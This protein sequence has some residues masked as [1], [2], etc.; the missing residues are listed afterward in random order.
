MV[1]PLRGASATPIK[2]ALRAADPFPGLDGFAGQLPDGRLVRDV[3]GREPL[4]VEGEDWAWDPRE[5]TDPDPFPAGSVG[6]PGAGPQSCLTIPRGR[7]AEPTVARDRLGAAIDAAL[8]A[9]PQGTPVGFSGGVDSGL[10]ATASAGPL[11]VVGLSDAPDVAA[12]R[13][14]ADAMGRRLR[15][16]D[17]S[18]SD[19]EEAVPRVARSIGLRDPM[20]VAIAMGFYQLGTAVAADGHDR[21]ALGQGADELF[22]GY[23]KVASAPT[24]DRL[25]AETVRDARDEMLRT[26]PHQAARD[27]A[28]LR[29]AGVEPVM[30]LLTDGVVTAALTLPSSMLVRDGVRKW[31]LRE[32]ARDRLPASVVGREKTAMQYGSRISREIDRLARQAGFKRRE[33]DHVRRYIQARVEET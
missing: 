27:V 6:P 10:V 20:D 19:I 3:L 8:G 12:A 25:S 7:A 16:V 4:F 2:A 1:E 24:D 11:Y 13:D 33:P 29:A 18:L 32:I 9:I 23:E 14:A 21:V 30:P 15:V 5:L 28:A 17:L 22:A 26:V 31:G